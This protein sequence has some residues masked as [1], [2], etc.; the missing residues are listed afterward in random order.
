MN[1]VLGLIIANIIWGAA[2]PI[3]KFALVNIP[4]FTLAFVRFF[5]ASLIL[6]PFALRNWKKI[7]LTNFALILLGAF[8]GISVNIGF[9]FLGLAKTESINAPVI[10]SSQPLFLYIFSIFFLRE[11]LNKKVFKGLLIALLGV[12]VIIFS[13]FLSNGGISLVAKEGAIEGNLFLLIATFGAVVH[14]LIFKSVLKNVNMWQV[15]FISFLFGALLFVPVMAPEFAS[16][17]FSDL[18]MNGWVGIIYGAI[19]SSA[20]AYGLYNYGVSKIKAQEVGIFTYIDPIVAVIIAVP[21]VHEHPTFAFYIGT[22]LVFVGIFIA[23]G[24]IHYHPFHRIW[25]P[26]VVK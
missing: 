4:P 12:M 15:T 25:R 23:E 21:L 14:T 19:F 13:P 20:I 8:F 9:F 17:S 3:F 16:W 24:R 7:S 1:P 11:K 18:T 26:K 10:A 2:S 5:G 22:F 6:L